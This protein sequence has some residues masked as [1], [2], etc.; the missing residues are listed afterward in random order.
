MLKQDAYFLSVKLYR[1]STVTAPGFEVST[2][3]ISHIL[4][5]IIIQNKLLN[6]FNGIR[7]C[8]SKQNSIILTSK[9]GHLRILHPLPHASEKSYSTLK[10]EQ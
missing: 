5:F 1:A 2:Y 9:Q 3:I 4:I 7:D 6:T 10:T 8:I